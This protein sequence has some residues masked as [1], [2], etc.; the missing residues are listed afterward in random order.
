MKSCIVLPVREGSRRILILQQGTKYSPPSVCV[1]EESVAVV[2]V[3]VSRTIACFF[4]YLER[5]NVVAACFCQVGATHLFLFVSLC[6]VV[7]QR[8]CAD[9]FPSTGLAAQKAAA[10]SAASARGAGGDLKKSSAGS[11]RI[12]QPRMLH[13]DREDLADVVDVLFWSGGKDSFLALR[14]L[15]REVTG[16]SSILLLTTFDFRSEIVAHQEVGID[17]VVRQARSLDI[18]LGLLFFKCI[19]GREVMNTKFALTVATRRFAQFLVSLN[20]ASYMHTAI[21][22]VGVPLNG[23]AGSYLDHATGALKWVALDGVRIRRLAF[24]DLHLAHVRAWRDKHLGGIGPGVELYYPLWKRDYELLLNELLETGTVV[25]VCAVACPEKV[26]GNV[27]VGDVFNR[28]LLERLP[29]SVDSFGEVRAL[30]LFCF[31]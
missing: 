6:H 29:Q 19:S 22:S 26:N 13:G 3:C 27:R 12:P 11:V 23:A 10:E 25:R 2:G 5:S 14:Q 20:G 30:L 7:I 21:L 18:A 4:S 16:P 1:L 17:T 8:H 24:G 15:A 9:A 28:S 31:H